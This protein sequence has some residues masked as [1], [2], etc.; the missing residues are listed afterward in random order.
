MVLGRL[1]G[2]LKQ[3]CKLGPGV[4]AAHVDGPDRLDLWPWRLDAKQVRGLAGLDA[5]PELLLGREQKVLVER[6]GRNGHLHPFA[7]AGNDRQHR[8]PG[9]GD[10]HVVLQLGHVLLGRAF[11]RERPW[12]HELG[13]EHRAGPLDHAVEGC[14]H[15]AL[16]RMK[17][18]PLHLGD[19]LAGI[20]LVPVPVEVLGHGAEL[21]D[22]V[23]REVL[24]LDLAAL[25]PPQP[26]QGGFVVAHDDPGVR[27]ADEG[28]AVLSQ[29]LSECPISCLSPCR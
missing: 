10:P 11:L 15:P 24:G 17:H 25:F 7:A 20:A 27:A 9:G 21:D 4:G 12:Q 28:A 18:L 19:D 5:A 1:P 13:L 3:A 14:R 6:I 16:D 8:R 29:L 2:C 26:E 23:V 22:Q